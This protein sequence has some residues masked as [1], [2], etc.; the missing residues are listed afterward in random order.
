MKLIYCQEC[1]S[2]FSLHLSTRTFCLCGESSGGY[3]N[4]TDNAWY[5]GP[6]IPLWLNDQSLQI[7]IE[8]RS[9]PLQRSF[10]VFVAADGETDFKRGSPSAKSIHAFVE[11]FKTGSAKTKW[12][13]SSEGEAVDPFDLPESKEPE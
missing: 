13:D 9:K 3:V 6:C 1:Q 11:G 7:A 4:G 12:A 8:N 5:D 10:S 2:I